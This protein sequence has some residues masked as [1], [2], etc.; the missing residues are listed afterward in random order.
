ME[1]LSINGLEILQTIKR[2]YERIFFQKVK[3][4]QSSFGDMLRVRLKL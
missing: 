2:D 3:K 4:N 1:L